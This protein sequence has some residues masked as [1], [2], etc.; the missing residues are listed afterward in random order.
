VS[1]RGARGRFDRDTEAEFVDG[2]R[3]DAEG[4]RDV[5][6]GGREVLRDGTAESTRWDRLRS[7]LVGL[8]AKRNPSVEQ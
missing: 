1:D 3:P 8:T 6:P 4:G 7:G 2:G 5:A